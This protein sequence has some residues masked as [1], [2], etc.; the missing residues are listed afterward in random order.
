MLIEAPEGT[1]KTYCER[2]NIPDVYGSN[3]VFADS[4]PFDKENPDS[5][6]ANMSRAY[7]NAIV[8]RD[9]LSSNVLSYLQLAV[10]I[11]EMNTRNAPLLELQPVIDYILAF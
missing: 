7:D 6:I 5:L 3:D 4:Y 10:D 8:L 2:L 9:E 1:Y 11:F